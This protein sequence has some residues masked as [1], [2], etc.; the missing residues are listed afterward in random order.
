M[1]GEPGDCRPARSP[2]GRRWADR[3]YWSVLVDTV[4]EGRAEVSLVGRTYRGRVPSLVYREYAQVIRLEQGD[5]TAPEVVE[6]IHAA[7]AE[8]MGR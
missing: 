6:V 2:D 7:M 4:E 1:G 5:L 8:L 3:V